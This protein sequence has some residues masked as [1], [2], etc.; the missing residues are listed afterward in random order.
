MRTRILR[1]GRPALTDLTIS[2][3]TDA[4]FAY[5]LQT[6]V[7]I[8][9]VFVL[10]LVFLTVVRRVITPLVRVAVREQMAGDPEVEIVKRVDTLAH[11]IYRTM[12][13]AV[14][15]V[16]VVTVLP[17]FGLNAAPLV[18]SLGLF[19]LAVGFGAQNLIKDMINGLFILMENQYG[20]GDVVTVAGISGLVEDLNLR[21]TVLRDLDG[22][23][24]FIPHSQVDKASNLTKGYSRV[25]LNVNVAYDSDLD[26]VFDVIDRV[27]QELAADP[28][29]ARLVLS[30]PKAL[31]VD[32]LG[33]SGIEIKVLGDTLPIEQWTVMGELRR[34]LKAAFEEEG[35][36][37]PFP[38]LTVHQTG[39]D[40]RGAWA[41]RSGGRR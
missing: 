30:P 5:L 2:V 4:V 12:V 3:D 16:A 11:V 32:K 19:G 22:T 18:A 6:G 25:N 38:Q 14:T 31:R 29:F 7:R 37:I 17:E 24:H 21:R 33:E 35:I 8:L 27:G 20:R 15:V 23:V 40:S 10:A 13:I 41:E 1:G 9:V 26:R 28:E 39:S 36:V 34:R